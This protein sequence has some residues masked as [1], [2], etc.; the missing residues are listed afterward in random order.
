MPLSSHV[1]LLESLE[2]RRVF[3]VV[4]DVDPAF[5]DGGTTPLIT[6]FRPDLDNDDQIIM[7][8]QLDGKVIVAGSFGEP[9]FF[10]NRYNPD[11]SADPTFHG[12]IRGIPSVEMDYITGVRV[13]TDGSIFLVDNQLVRLDSSGEFAAV[14]GP[15]DW[16]INN[17]AVAP[18][19]KVIISDEMNGIMRYN[20]DGSLDTTFNGGQP[21]D[22]SDWDRVLAIEPAADGKIVVQSATGDFEGRLYDQLFRLGDDGAIDESFNNGW[23]EQMWPRESY[24]SMKLTPDGSILLAG[25]STRRVDDFVIRKF[26]PDGT[27]DNSFDGDGYVRTDLGSHSDYLSYAIAQSDGGVFAIGSFDNTHYVQVHYRPDGSLE[28]E[29]GNDGMMYST[30]RDDLYGVSAASDADGGVIVLSLSSDY[31]N[32]DWGT[33]SA[34]FY[35]TRYIFTT[36]IPAPEKEDD[37]TADGEDE[38]NE[39]SAD[40]SVDPA[41]WNYDGGDEQR[42]TDEYSDHYVDVTSEEDDQL[43]WENNSDAWE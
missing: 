39:E 16:Q 24:R 27:P 17:W 23:I 40:I 33:P 10:I 34:G 30:L 29:W 3:S 1:F 20:A 43:D 7:H 19:G 13:R 22:L 12:G 38:H 41:W 28:S 37:P 5:G 21:V 6:D 31:M 2:P 14:Y 4:A 26:L 36:E 8:V 42:Q 15:K 9:A 18:G 25:G 35:L 11:G 32:S